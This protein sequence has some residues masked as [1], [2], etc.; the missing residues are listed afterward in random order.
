MNFPTERLQPMS[1]CIYE[2]DV[3][4]NANDVLNKEERITFT[5][6]LSKNEF[7][8][9]LRNG[10]S[11]ALHYRPRHFTDICKQADETYSIKSN[12]KWADIRTGIHHV[13]VE[14]TVTEEFFEHILM[15]GIKDII[16]KSCSVKMGRIW[17]HTGAADCQ[18][19][20]EKTN[21]E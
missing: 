16:G 13:D 17:L 7:E 11:L 18:I 12:K 19:T 3:L 2:D 10:M 5:V 1:E 14:H 4:N 9:I 8:K 6:Q 15:R 21:E 20:F